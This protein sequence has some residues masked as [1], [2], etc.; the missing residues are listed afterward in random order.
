MV[1]RATYGTV[2]AVGRVLRKPQHRFYVHHMPFQIQPFL[3][4]PVIP[5]ETMKNALLQSRVVTDP[6]AN[7][8]IGWW[9]EYYF[10]YVKHRDL[11]GREDFTAMQL[12]LQH[13]M[14]AYVSA[15]DVK[16]NHHANAINWS[17]LCLD[18]VVETYFRDEGTAAGTYTI[19]G[20]PAA[21]VN[22]EAFWQSAGLNDDYAVGDVAIPTVADIDPVTGGDQPGIYASQID[23][24]LQ[25]WQFQRANNLTEMNYEDWL[26]TYGI[27]VPRVETHV[28]ELLRYVREWQYPSNTVS[29]GTGAVTSAVSWAV[30]DRLDKD[31]FFREPGFIFG[32][33]LARPKVYMKNVDGN[34]VDMM[35]NALTW[36]PALMRDDPWTS[37]K[38]VA[39][40][41]GPLATVV[42]DSDGYWVD[43]K[44]L[45]LYGDDFINVA[46]S[47][48][49][50]NMVSLPGSTLVNKDFPSDADVDG[51]FVGDTDDERQVR[52]DGIV[53]LNILGAQV[54]TTPANS[55]AGR[56]M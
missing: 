7:K 40:D 51:L 23:I 11:D 9:I 12:N 4:A 28:P 22:V 24:A 52:Q 39:Q 55:M 19:D 30:S 20:M 46:R 50:L 43:V 35:D 8:L 34:G 56:G 47:T 17:K 3:I 5:G 36:L 21:A 42:T 41:R 38:K 26:A 37:M 44:D 48:A 6:I 1:S 31:R 13:D 54:D 14:S 33:T 27:A 16:H 15:A 49:G 2:P 32:V 25:T 18:R 53:T 29:E 10:F 45:L